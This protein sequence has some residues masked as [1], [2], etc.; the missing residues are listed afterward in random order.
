MGVVE[1]IVAGVLEVVAA[2]LEVFELIR[3]AVSRM[4]DN[5]FTQRYE[6]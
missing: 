1:A 2:V 4:P 5:S 3:N 6:A